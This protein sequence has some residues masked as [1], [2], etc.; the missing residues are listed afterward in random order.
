MNLGQTDRRRR[1]E[2][3]AAEYVLG[4]LPR[5]ARARMRR[6]AV[7]DPVVARVIDEWERRLC[8]LAEAAPAVAPPPRVWEAIAKRLAFAGGASAGGWWMRVAF[9]RAFAIASF[10]AFVAL[11]VGTLVSREQPA[12]A[13][14][15]VLAGSDAKPALVATASRSERAL[16]VKAVGAIPLP[17]GRALELWMLPTDGAPRSMG[18]VDA[19]GTVTLPLRSPSGTFLADAKGLAITL[20]PA[21]GSPTGAPTGPILYSGKIE[22]I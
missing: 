10:A 6:A 13:I 5:Q 1:L 16:H 12:G 4:T 15:V 2:L 18:L 8:G 19:N 17:A 22:T 7:A 9:W 3:V 11:G 14:V 20:E 21:G